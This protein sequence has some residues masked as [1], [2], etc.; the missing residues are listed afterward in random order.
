VAKGADPAEE[1][2]SLRQ[3]LTVK[4]LCEVYLKAAEKGLVMGKGGRAK[5]AT[6]LYADKGRIGRHLTQLAAGEFAFLLGMLLRRGR[7]PASGL[8]DVSGSAR[9]CSSPG[10]VGRVCLSRWLAVVCL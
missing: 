8:R 4:E 5:K 1:R 7:S 6:T 2:A 9:L 10:R 3:A